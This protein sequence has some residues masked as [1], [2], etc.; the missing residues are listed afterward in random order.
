MSFE[1]FLQVQPSPVFFRPNIVLSPFFLPGSLQAVP[2]INS[3][4]TPSFP[5]PVFWSFPLFLFPPRERPQHE[6]ASFSFCLGKKR[7]PSFSS[8]QLVVRFHFAIRFSLPIS[9]VHRTPPFP[10]F[11]LALKRS[12]F[13]DQSPLLAPAHHPL[14]FGE[15]ARSGHL[16]FSWRKKSPALS[17]N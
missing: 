12:F 1:Q 10:S 8:S 11:F 4:G 13:V 3:V 6:S 16:L 7:E 14:L 17:Y 2:L 9:P 15:P 5:F